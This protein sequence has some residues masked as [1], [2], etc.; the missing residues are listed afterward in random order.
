M[1]GSQVQGQSGLHSEIL[2][3]KDGWAAL[4][5]GLKAAGVLETVH[6]MG[7]DEATG[8]CF[9]WGKCWIHTERLA[10]HGGFWR[11]WRETSGK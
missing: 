11:E 7:R 1:N 3:T 6:R 4:L 8:F 9:S 10:G 5:K 2:S